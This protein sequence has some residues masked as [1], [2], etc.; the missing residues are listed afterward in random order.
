LP[1]VRERARWLPNAVAKPALAPTPLPFDPPVLL[2]LGRL[3]EEK[4]F[5]LALRTLALLTGRG[6]RARMRVVGDG[7][8]RMQLE[9]LAR[10]LPVEFSDGVPHEKVPELIN[11]TTLALIPSRW[12]EPFGLV[13]LDAALMARPVVATRVGGLSEVIEGGETGLLVEPENPVALAEA[14]ES[15]LRDPARLRAMGE[16]AKERV[17]RLFSFEAGVESQI[18]WYEEALS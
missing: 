12:Q 11:T 17:E 5:D 14:I 8:E 18:A 7:P 6:R 10:G 2:C 13:V 4:G 3:V 16:Q 9:E 1:A 15:L